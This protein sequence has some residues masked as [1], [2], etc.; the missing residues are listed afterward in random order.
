M[1]KLTKAEETF[2]NGDSY[3]PDC[4]DDDDVDYVDDE[5]YD[6]GGHYV[7]AEDDAFVADFIRDQAKDEWYFFTKQV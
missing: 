2:L 1:K 3:C 7:G 6:A 5:G 4:Y